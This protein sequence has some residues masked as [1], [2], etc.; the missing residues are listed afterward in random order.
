MDLSADLSAL[1]PRWNIEGADVLPPSEPAQI[2]TLFAQLGQ[3]ATAE[4]VALYS[5]LGG[6]ATMDNE[7]WRMWSLQE[8]QE[9]NQGPPSDWGVLFSDYLIHSHVFRLR[10]TAD[11]ASSEVF[12]DFLREDIAPI[13]VAASLREF[14][15]LYRSD[16]DRVLAL[17]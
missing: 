10:T 17:R 14:F 11:G 15:A 5:T 16:P 12:A 13:R 6:M 1:I 8:I 7:F 9:E 4:V 3:P 2:E